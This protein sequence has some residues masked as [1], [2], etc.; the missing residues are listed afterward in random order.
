VTPLLYQNISPR[1]PSVLITSGV[2]LLAACLAAGFLPARTAGRADP[3]EALQA[4]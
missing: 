2:V 1:D 4:E 3:R